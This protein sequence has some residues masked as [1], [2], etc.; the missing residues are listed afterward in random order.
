MQYYR[1]WK[2]LE[3]SLL[4]TE[5]CIL[6]GIAPHHL[7]TVRY[8]TNDDISSISARLTTVSGDDRPSG[9]T[10]HAL[11]ELGNGAQVTYMATYESAG[12]DFFEGGREFYMRI[13]GDKATLH[14]FQRWLFLARPGQIPRPVRRG[15]R[16][17][18]EEAILLSQ[19]HD[20]IYAGK[21]P[22]C[23]G[24]DNLQT[25]AAIE[26]CLRSSEANEAIDPRKLLSD[27]FG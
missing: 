3:P 4:Q 16:P 7:D 2:D 20:A 12:Q 10:M 19:L 26:A 25:M 17:E 21:E 8:V 14:V 15:P 22:E 18:T 9:A 11:M 24:R 23:S 13:V 1:P 6:W 5:N 27:A